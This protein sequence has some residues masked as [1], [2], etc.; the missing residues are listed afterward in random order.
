MDITT[1]KDLYRH[2]EWA[3]ACVWTSVLASDNGPTDS[4]LRNCLYHLH[5]A[6]RA[7]LRAWRNEPRETPYPTFDDAPSLMQW[8]RSYYPEACSHLENLTDREISDPLPERWGSVAEQRLGRTPP[9][10]TFGDTALQVVLHGAY[11]RGQINARLRE[12][13]GEPPLVDYIA[14]VWRGRPTADWPSVA[15]SGSPGLK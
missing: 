13:G 7:F 15:S 6:Q 14:W 8:G 4:R 3:D 10:T 12:V 9:A 2:L 11:H 5:V 1:I